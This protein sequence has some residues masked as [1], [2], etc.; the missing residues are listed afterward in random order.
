MDKWFIELEWIIVL[1]VRYQKANGEKDWNW[2]WSG[3]MVVKWIWKLFM[4]KNGFLM[5]IKM[6][7]G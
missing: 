5:D 3:L 2:I 6:D 7:H 4:N 1:E